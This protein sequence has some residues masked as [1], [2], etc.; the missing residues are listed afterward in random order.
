MGL[1]LILGLDISG[2]RTVFIL[3]GGG[4]CCWRFLVSSDRDGLLMLG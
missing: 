3:R 2:E 1:G 4:C